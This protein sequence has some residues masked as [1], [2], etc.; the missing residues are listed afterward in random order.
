MLSN[1]DLE[2]SFRGPLKI[3]IQAFATKL[4]NLLKLSSTTGR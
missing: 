3:I 2:G 1:K 4:E